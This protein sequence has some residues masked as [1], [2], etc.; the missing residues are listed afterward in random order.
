MGN[1]EAAL[2]DCNES[3]RLLPNEPNAL[4][5]RAL[6]YLKLKQYDQAIADYDAVLKLQ[7]NTPSALYGRGLAKVKK[8]DKRGQA[9]I[10]S[11]QAAVPQIAD[12]FARYGIK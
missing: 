3:L 9:D 7:P 8:G 12:E 2:S 11:A 10:A 5:S 4:D 6:V 1:L